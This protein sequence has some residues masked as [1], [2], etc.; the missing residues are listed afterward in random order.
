MTKERRCRTCPVAT[1]PYKRDSTG[2]VPIQKCFHQVLK[3]KTC[4]FRRERG[5][6]QKWNKN[7]TT[8][9]ISK[10]SSIVTRKKPHHKKVKQKFMCTAWSTPQTQILLWM[11]VALSPH[12]SFHSVSLQISVHMLCDCGQE[13]QLPRV[14]YEW[15]KDCLHLCIDSAVRVSQHF[16][17]WHSHSFSKTQTH[18]SDSFSV[19]AVWTR[20]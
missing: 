11:N 7:R 19:L 1:R 14:H 15:S 16:G 3:L 12:L 13:S 6:K 18:F 8:T 17:D 10:S 9:L 4:K 20:W 2:S 5:R